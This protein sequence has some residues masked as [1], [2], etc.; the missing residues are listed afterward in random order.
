MHLGMAVVAGGDA[1]VCTGGEDLVQF[2]L[3]VF[4]AGIRQTGLQEAATAAAAEIIGAVGGHVDEVLFTHNGFYH[5]PQV[6]RHRVAEALPDQ[7][8]GIL[9]GEFDL[10]VFVPVGIDLEFALSDPLGIILNDAFD[11]EFVVDF[12]FVQSGPDC[13]KFVPSLG[14]EPDLGLQIIH[15]LCLDLDDVFP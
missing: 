4:P 10:A 7:L 1:V 5:K 9:D 2:H 14:I 11:F 6:F 3:A 15:R 12:E 13:E 8:A